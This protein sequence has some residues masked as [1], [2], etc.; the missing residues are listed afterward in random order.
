MTE[1]RFT[2]RAESWYAMTMWPGYH[3]GEPYRS[4]IQ[5]FSCVPKGERRFEMDFLNV[6]YAEGIQGTIKSF[7]TL[8][9]G[10]HVLAA[11]EVECEDRLYVFEPLT[12]PWLER[13]FPAQSDVA[14][15][16]EDPFLSAWVAALK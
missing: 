14:R 10:R 7:Q 1:R 6:C 8:Q 15:R 9:R 5:V 12:R 16:V 13:F 3:A 2:F 4:P 11:T